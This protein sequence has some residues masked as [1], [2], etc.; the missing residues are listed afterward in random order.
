VFLRNIF[1]KN[2]NFQLEQFSTYKIIYIV[3]DVAEFLNGS[4]R[5]GSLRPGNQRKDVGFGK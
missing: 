3:D 4:G 1:Q 5:K 2:N